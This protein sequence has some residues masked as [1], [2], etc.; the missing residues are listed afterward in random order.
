MLKI[1]HLH[2]NAFSA[3]GLIEEVPEI[4]LQVIIDELLGSPSSMSFINVCEQK[5]EFDIRSGVNFNRG[6][7]YATHPLQTKDS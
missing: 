1:K 2:T 5:G 7:L 3:F 6:G 4:K